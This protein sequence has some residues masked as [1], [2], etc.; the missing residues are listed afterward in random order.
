[1]RRNSPGF[2]PVA[3]RAA[4]KATLEKGPSITR[5]ELTQSALSKVPSKNVA[6][7][8]F[9]GGAKSAAVE[10]AMTSA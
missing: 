1:L 4:E 3:D 5:I 2:P 7:A 6:V 10:T 8:A 9:A